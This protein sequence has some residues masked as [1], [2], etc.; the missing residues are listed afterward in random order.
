MISITN[1]GKKFPCE[2]E[3]FNAFSE[4][5]QLFPINTLI[6]HLKFGIVSPINTSSHLERSEIPKV[7]R[8]GKLILTSPP[9]P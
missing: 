2:P 1:A 9:S 6:R 5:Y 3:W 8:F 4:T 7:K